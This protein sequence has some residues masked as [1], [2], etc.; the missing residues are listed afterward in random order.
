LRFWTATPTSKV[1]CADITRVEPDQPAYEIFSIKRRFQQSKS[2]ALYQ[3]NLHTQLQYRGIHVGQ[4]FFVFHVPHFFLF[5][6]SYFS[7]LL[8]PNFLR[9]LPESGAPSPPNSYVHGSAF[10]TYR[11]LSA[12]AKTVHKPNAARTE[13]VIDWI[14]SWTG[15]PCAIR[16]NTAGLTVSRL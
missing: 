12:H 14:H 9:V 15:W 13:F 7:F 1:N 16:Y 11:S 8:C 4:F 6:F 3:G 5:F 2:R 10:I